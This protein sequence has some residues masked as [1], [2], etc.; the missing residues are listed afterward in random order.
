MT[1][2]AREVAAV[3]LAG[4][5]SSR[6]GSLGRVLPKCLLPVPGG[7]TL[8]T[9]LIGQLR[10]AGVPQVVVC[11]S[12][13]GAPLIEPFL[14][15]YRVAGA[16]SDEELTAVPCPKSALGP[17]PALAEALSRVAAPWYLLALADVV[18]AEGPFAASIHRLREGALEDGCLLTGSD[19]VARNG[20]GTGFIASDGTAARAISYR[21]FGPAP[22]AQGRLRRWSGSFLFRQELVPDLSGRL[23]AYRTAPLEDWIDGL[24]DR[25]DRC[26]CMD[27][28]P[29]FN[30][31]AVEDYRLLLTAFGAGAGT[32]SLDA[33]GT[34]DR[35]R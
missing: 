29:F 12:P 19:Q 33:Y 27:A 10:Q 16:L 5:K 18:F 4:G 35:E 17:L 1:R 3:I 6:F 21:P 13:G 25:G 8:L 31:N 14:E 32:E 20:F 22:R 9:R 11:C 7:E 34:R 15:R 26:E 24:L 2:S 28:G 30:V 23:A